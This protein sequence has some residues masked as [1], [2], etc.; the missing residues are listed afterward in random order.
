[1]RGRAAS[2]VTIHFQLCNGRHVCARTCLVDLW[3]DPCWTFT[4]GMS[5]ARSAL[6]R[7]ASALYSASGFSSGCPFRPDSEA[8][9]AC[10]AAQQKPP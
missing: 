2:Q 3:A 6:R 1:M 4:R 8:A 5:A 7:S 10:T 9:P